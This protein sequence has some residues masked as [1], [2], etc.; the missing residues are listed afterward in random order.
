MLWAP[1]AINNASTTAHKARRRTQPFSSVAMTIWIR[2]RARAFLMTSLNMRLMLGLAREQVNECRQVGSERRT[3]PGTS[4]HDLS[5]GR[6]IR[7]RYGCVGY[8]NA[9][10]G[11]VGCRQ[12]RIPSFANCGE[13][14]LDDVTW[15][16]S[17]GIVVGELASA[18]LRTLKTFSTTR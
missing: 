13:L 16:W 3:F 1:R 4:G 11:D 17:Q 6:Q 12:Y 5:A 8:R 7:V 9:S 2:F 15:N 18:A 14:C 10:G